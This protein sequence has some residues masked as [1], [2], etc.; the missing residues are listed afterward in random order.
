MIQINGFYMVENDLSLYF[1]NSFQIKRVLHI[2]IVTVL[3][4]NFQNTA[5]VWELNFY[6][7]LTVNKNYDLSYNNFSSAVPIMHTL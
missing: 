2:A 7:H 4:I 5:T 6:T 1:T 3:K